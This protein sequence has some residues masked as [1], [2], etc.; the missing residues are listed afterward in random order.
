M[1]LNWTLNECYIYKDIKLKRKRK[2]A[3]RA[4]VYK[5]IKLAAKALVISEPIANFHARHEKL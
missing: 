4:D 2:R 3:I 5:D 1:A